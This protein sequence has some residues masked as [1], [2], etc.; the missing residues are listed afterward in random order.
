MFTHT[1][2]Y[3][4][5]SRAKGT[6]G[7][8]IHTSKD[9]QDVLSHVPTDGLKVRKLE[10]VCC[11]QPLLN[12]IG[13]RGSRHNNSNDNKDPVT[14]YLLCIRYCSACFV[15]IISNPHNYPVRS[16]FVG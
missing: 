11:A 14:E 16:N 7:K 13:S 5:G 2:T 6:A 3:T 15:S 9:V 1:H 4:W 10:E 12:L 8:G